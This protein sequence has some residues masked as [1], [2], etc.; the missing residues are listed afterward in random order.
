MF[1]LVF[2]VPS[3]HLESVKQAVFAVGAGELGDYC[4]CCWQVLGTGQFEPMANA[5]PFIGTQGA[6]E[7]VDEWR[8]EML[9]RGEALQ[10]TLAALRQAHPYEEP[11]FFVQKMYSIEG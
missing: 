7:T 6:L 4:Q 11:A 1:T 3:S 10:A 5:R 8:V 2:Y 9:V